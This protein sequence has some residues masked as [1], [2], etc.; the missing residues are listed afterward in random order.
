[1]SDISHPSLLRRLYFT[2]LRDLLRGRITAA[3]DYHAALADAALPAPI[4]QLREQTVRRT[5]LWRSEKT[6][7]AEELLAHFA[8]GLERQSTEQLVDAFGSIAAAAR[9]IRRGKKRN[10]PLAWKALRLV[11]Q[12]ITL[13]L[14]LCA[15]AA[16]RFFMGQPVHSVDYVGQL[17]QASAQAPLEDRAWPLYRRGLLSSGLSPP[18]RRVWDLADSFDVRPGDKD[19][20]SV[21]SWLKQHADAMELFRHAS[22]KPALGFVLGPGGSYDDDPQLYG[23]GHRFWDAPDSVPADSLWAIPIPYL[24][25]LRI[26]S[27][28]IGADAVLANEENDGPRCIAD[29][30]AMI[31]LAGQLQRQRLGFDLSDMVALGVRNLALDYADQVVAHGPRSLSDDQLRRLVHQLA[32]GDRAA[33]LIDLDGERMNFADVIQHVYTDDGHGDGRMTPAG[34]RLLWSAEEKQADP[35]AVTFLVGDWIRWAPLPVVAISRREAVEQFNHLMDLAELQL[36][37][38]LREVHDFAADHEIEAMKKSALGNWRYK[39]LVDCAVFQVSLVQKAAEQYLGHRDG[40]SVGIA[41]ALYHR[42]HGV[43]PSSLQ[44][45]VPDLLPAVPVDRITGEPVHYTIRDG[46]PIVYSV[47]ADRKDDGGVPAVT[48]SDMQGLP[49]PAAEWNVPANKAAHG[50]WILYPQSRFGH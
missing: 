24:T 43:Y 20:P 41:L 35:S 1:M 42:R 31:D 48:D 13:L 19:W 18:S 6:A 36:N 8:D 10:R 21:R 26:V 44:A 25:T 15:V 30:Q 45:L 50:D 7:L 2:P 9:L 22:A 46:I 37:R 11:G 47:G 3:Q 38:P 14:L 49:D 34:V 39:V 33:D 23:P 17:Q 4:R 40:V 12:M 29:I 27:E 5:R 28:A 32:N 16:G